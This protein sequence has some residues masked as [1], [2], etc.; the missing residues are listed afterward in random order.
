MCVCPMT[1]TACQ[2]QCFEGKRTGTSRWIYP[3]QKRYTSA[4]HCRNNKCQPSLFFL[5]SLSLS[6]FLPLIPSLS[7]LYICHIPIPPMQLVPSSIP[8]FPAEMCSSK[9]FT[10]AYA[11]E[12]WQLQVSDRL[13]SNRGLDRYWWREVL[14]LPPPRFFSKHPGLIH[15]DHFFHLISVN[16]KKM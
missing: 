11:K 1:W 12:K 8:R 16:R 14:F 10:L 5:P 7:L 3:P 13:R 2:C 15:N 6:V 9:H 4:E